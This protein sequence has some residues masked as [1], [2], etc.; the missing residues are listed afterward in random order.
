MGMAQGNGE[1]VIKQKDTVA[2]LIPCYNEAATVA[3]VIRDFRK[4]LPE[5]VIYVYDNNSTDQT[6]QIARDEGAIVKREYHQGKGSVVRSMFR[7]INA[8]IFI[9]VDG[10]DTYPADSCHKFIECVKAGQAD[11]VVGDR[12]SNG[13][14]KNENQRAFHSFGNNL[15]KSAINL[16]FRAQL[17]DIMTGYRCFNRRFVKTIPTLSNKFEIETEMTLHALDKRFLIKE[18]PIIYCDRPA[19][20]V[21]KLNTVSDGFRVLRTIFML[22]KDFKPLVFF[23]VTSLMLLITGILTGIPVLTDY[24]LYRYIYHVPLAIL[25]TGIV[26]LSALSFICGIILDTVVKQYRY[27]YEL[28]LNNYLDT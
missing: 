13:S 28:H 26:L 2:V 27:L 14:Y 3:K 1:R 9:L 22:F 21:S 5:A 20:S 11:M 10:D 4:Q 23:S 18:I 15:V 25:S 17:N 16:L 12:L 19:G 7:D 8:D 24:I 6:A